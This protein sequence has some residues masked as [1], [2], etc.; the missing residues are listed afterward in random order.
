MTRPSA[1]AKETLIPPE[2]FLVPPLSV[3]V[4]DPDKDS[5][6]N[7]PWFNMMCQKKK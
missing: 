2:R 1:A 6:S 5:S 7:R 4:K 3:G